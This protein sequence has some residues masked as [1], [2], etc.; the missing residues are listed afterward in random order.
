MTSR[1]HTQPFRLC[2][3]PLLAVKAPEVGRSENL[4]GG[5]LEDVVGAIAKSFGVKT[6]NAGSLLENIWKSQVLKDDSVR[7]NI[8]LVACNDPVTLD[9]RELALKKSK[10]HSIL[11]LERVHDMNMK[12]GLVLSH[13]LLSS[14]RI[15]I[16][17][18][19]GKQK[20]RIS[21]EDHTLGSVLS[22]E[23]H[24]KFG[25]LFGIQ[26]PLTRPV[27]ES[28]TLAPVHLLLDGLSL[29]RLRFHHDILTVLQPGK[30]GGES[31]LQIVHGGSSHEQ[32]VL[33]RLES[34]K[35]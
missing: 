4:R 11:K 19:K 9:P 21:T 29:L 14:V 8:G 24:I 30:Y 18:I 32:S 17:T 10:P 33:Q 31:S 34:V 13:T 23:A 12:C 27:T 7:L 16:S 22:F 2:Q 6:G 26:H 5:D 28:S 1:P 25:R 20:A 3:R 35:A 15:D